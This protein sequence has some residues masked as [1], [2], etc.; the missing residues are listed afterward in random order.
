MGV[1][2]GGGQPLFQ[3][4]GNGGLAGARQSRKPQHPGLL[5]LQVAARDLVH[6][7]RLP[8]DVVRGAARNESIPRPE[9]RIDTTVTSP[10]DTVEQIVEKLASVGVMGG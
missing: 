2:S 7:Q 5:A 10:D 3:R 8:M 9:I 6:I 4:I 1:L